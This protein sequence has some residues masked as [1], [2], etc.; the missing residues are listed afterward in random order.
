MTWLANTAVSIIVC[1]LAIVGAICG[2]LSAYQHFEIAGVHL[3][4]KVP[5]IGRV[6]L[7]NI[8]GL[9]PAYE[10]DEADLKT[11]RANQLALQKGLG[12]CNA[13][14]TNLMAKGGLATKA[15]ETGI[16]GNTKNIAAV[17]ANI[18]AVKKMASNATDSC[19]EGDLI[20]QRAFQ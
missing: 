1:A 8:D 16:S 4:F 19:H 12:I 3:G 11:F 17:N 9:R 18:A 6:N 13:S 14:I 5:V 2:P 10:K 7:I 20:L 15:A